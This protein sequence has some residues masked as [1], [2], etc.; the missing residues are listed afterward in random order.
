MLSARRGAQVQGAGRH[1]GALFL[2]DERRKTKHIAEPGY[3]FVVSEDEAANI[4]RYGGHR[5]FDLVEVIY[6]GPRSGQETTRIEGA[7]PRVVRLAVG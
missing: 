2:F 5:H 3:E 4:F 6:D 7:M 1:G